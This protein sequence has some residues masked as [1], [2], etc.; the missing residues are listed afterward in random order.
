VI[1]SSLD[2]NYDVKDALETEFYLSG[3]SPSFRAGEH[4][5][6]F[7]RN[8]EQLKLSKS[9]VIVCPTGSEPV[10]GKVLIRCA[11]PRLGFIKLASAHFPPPGPH[12][13]MGKS[14]SLYQ[15]VVL[16]SDGF[17]YERDEEG[18]LFKF[19]HYGGIVIGNNVDI[20][21]N[22]CIDRGSLEDTEIGD[23]TKIDNLVH[24][25][26]NAKIGKHCLLTALSLIGGSAQIGDYS[27]I[28]SAAVIKD[29]VKI[30]HHAT[31]GAGA[32]VINDVEPFST[33]V[34]VPAKDIR[35]S[36]RADT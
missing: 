26:H 32:V 23:G 9:R 13:T 29:H 18:K 21:A 25:G 11:N 35:Q 27:T 36:R 7:V 15:G 24:V 1:L 34:G 17:G 10:D 5:L 4:E 19:P 16:G 12:I 8:V 14:V 28:W 20:G 31:I 30:G 3:V 22:T 2:A 6:T 33:V